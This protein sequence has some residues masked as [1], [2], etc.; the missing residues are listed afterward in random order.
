M[1]QARRLTAILA[2][3]GFDDGQ[4]DSVAA[5]PSCAATV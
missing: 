2:D 1:T 4:C 3:V 5:R